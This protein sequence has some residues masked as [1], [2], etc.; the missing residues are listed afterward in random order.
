[1]EI[2]STDHDAL[3]AIARA[4]HGSQGFDEWNGRFH[5]PLLREIYR[6]VVTQL[7]DETCRAHAL[8]TWAAIAEAEQQS[9]RAGHPASALSTASHPEPWTKTTG[10]TL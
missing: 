1:M 8:P 3:F 9:A 6:L 5:D 10:E 4:I 7:D 2:P